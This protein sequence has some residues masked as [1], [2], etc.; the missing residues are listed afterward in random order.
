MQVTA[1]GHRGVRLVQLVSYW[2]SK[3]KKVSQTVGF[4]HNHIE[5][6]KYC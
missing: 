2:S 5:D 1:G 4:A 3:G 6:I